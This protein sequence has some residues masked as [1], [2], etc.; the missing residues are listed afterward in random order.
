[1]K[2]AFN[3]KNI[4]IYV[5]FAIFFILDRVFKGLAL[6]FTA[7]T[8]LIGG[9][10]KFNLS[11]NY[12]IAFSLP[13]GDSYLILALT[14]VVALLIIYFIYLVIRKYPRYIYL[15]LLLIIIGAIGNLIDRYLY[16]FIVD[17]LDIGNFTV[18]NIADILIT[19]GAIWLL[20]SSFKIKTS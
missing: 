4:A 1:M 8:N 10:I 12:N 2:S 17:Y 9:F 16:G 13:I 5:M 15:P 7:E 6:H 20:S 19:G 11:K 3:I 14:L 18:L